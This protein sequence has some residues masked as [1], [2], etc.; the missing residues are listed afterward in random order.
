MK[1]KY[2][3]RFN[4]SKEGPELSFEDFKSIMQDIVDQFDFEYDFHDY[5]KDE[6]G[7]NWDGY[8]GFYDV[9]IYMTYKE[10]YEIHDDIPHMNLDFLDYTNQILSPID[11]PETIDDAKFE[12]IFGYLDGNREDLEEVKND[13]D[14][15]IERNKKA[16]LVFQILKDK[17][18]PRLS[19]FSNFESCSVGFEGGDLRITFDIDNETN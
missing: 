16:K 2:L 19:H 4:E 18:I 11:E 3:K 17:I 12:E 15:I 1:Y 7:E 8:E 14:D 10:G 9:W 13:L 6:E 5:S